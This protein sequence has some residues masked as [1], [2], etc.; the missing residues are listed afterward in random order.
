MNEGLVREKIS[1]VFE[2]TI[3]WLDNVMVVECK[4]SEGPWPS[5]ETPHSHPHEQ[6]TYVADGEIE[7]FKGEEKLFLTKNDF[8]LIPPGVL[9][10]IRLVSSNAILID[11]FSPVRKEFIR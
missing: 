5:R 1:P 4:F 2:R 11:S 10:C 8:V 3:A 7:F 6:I 9:H